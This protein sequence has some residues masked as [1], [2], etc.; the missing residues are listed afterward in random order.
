[1]LRGARIRNLVAGVV[2][3]AFV[4]AAAWAAD[5]PL[6]LLDSFVHYALIANTELA[7]GNGQ[8]LLDSGTSDAEL[9]QLVED[10]R[11]TV[12][13]FD[14]AVERANRNADMQGVAAEL[15]QR[16]EKGRLD[17]ARDPKR[18][19]EAIGMLVGTQR[20]KMLA[21]DRLRHA[22]EYAVPSL[23]REIT[24]GDVVNVAN[25]DVELLKLACQQMIV[26]IG[27]QAA[28]PLCESLVGLGP[29]HQRLVCD[30]LGDLGCPQAAPYLKRLAADAQA[31]QPVRDSAQRAL[32]RLTR[33]DK[34][35]SEMFTDLA[36]D[37]FDEHESLVA[38]PSEPM[39]NVWS[40]DPH[41]GLVATPVPTAVFC[42]IMSARM[43]S[44]AIKIE[45][46]NRRALSFF[47][48]ANL[49]RENDLPEGAND[50][51]YGANKY[52][53]SFYATVFGTQTCLD[54]LTL[55]LDHKDT[56]LIRDAIASLSKTT[57]GPSLF[58]KEDSGQALLAA[59][60]YPDRRVQLEAAL[61]LAHA[62]PQQ[63][64]T[65]DQV[66]VPVLAGAVRTGNKSYAVVIGENN[67]DRSAQAAALEK[68]GFTI[69]AS[70]AGTSEVAKEINESIAVDLVLVRMSTKE[71]DMQVIDELRHLSKAAAS[72][73][74]VIASAID[75][76]QLKLDTRAD[77]RV[78]I[79]NAGINAE[80]FGMNVDAAM[81]SGSGGRMTD[82]EAEEYAILALSA[83][84]DLAISQNPVLKINDAEGALVEALQ[85]RTGGIRMKVADILAMLD[86]DNAQRQ[87]F[88]AALSAQGDDQ[89][90]LLGHVADSV[91][92]NGDHAEKRHIDALLDL[93]ADSSGDVADAAAT[94]HG[95]LNL[96]ASDAVKL[97]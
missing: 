2:L 89:V 29:A 20:G 67:E 3:S 12:E 26:K 9:A 1:M 19:N 18:I 86:T 76:P 34:S 45:S 4:S 62:L 5:T 87:L 77:R 8:A 39:N 81:K 80:Q 23:L 10:N 58:S 47:V 64:F 17:L 61:T 25:T 14:R 73:V 66:V 28:T 55:A 7:V 38:F 71:K 50:P 43:A 57:G 11:V 93:V 74:L 33:G 53:P 24:D 63:G 21:E 95:A 36:S 85:T 96:G 82:A 90:E 52:S 44:T 69:T 78:V 60:Q 31:D 72:P 79:A 35:V 49:R 54:V 42:E 15:S 51:I 97:I 37:Y 56:P 68:L 32:E 94:V 13:R 83:L 92:H 65:N 59:L 91:R 46:T 16:V 40:Y 30:M 48:A 88:D 75:M 70:G 84:R 6:D 27:C 22:G 41:V